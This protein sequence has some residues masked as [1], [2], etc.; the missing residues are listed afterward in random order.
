MIVDFIRRF[1]FS[2]S[3]YNYFKKEQLIHNKRLYEK[4]GLNKKY[5]SSISSKDFIGL[6]D[7]KNWLDKENSKTSLLQ[8]NFFKN[9]PDQFKEPLLNW[10]DNGFV[11][12]PKMF[13]AETQKINAEIEQ[14]LDKKIVKWK[15]GKKI[16]FAIQKSAYLSSIGL[17]PQ[18][19]GVMQMLLGRKI[20]L[21]QSINFFSGSQQRTHSDF[22]HMSTFPKGNLIA[23]WIALEDMCEENGPLH[24]YPGS[25]KLPCILNKDYQND[26]NSFM[27]GNKTYDKYEDEVER[28][29]NQTDLKKDKF[30]AK[31]GDALI[32]HSNLL[33]GG[34]EVLNPKLTR[35]SMVFHYY[36]HDVICYHE[37]TQR[38]TIME[39]LPK[40]N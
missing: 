23:V 25:H 2:F 16:M 33:H 6:P 10:S 15:N 30:I 29:L 12:L 36:A 35:K 9:L 27:V 38:P 39:K 14:L 11:V 17:N 28:I 40:F 21:F 34:E 32:W 24:Y 5:Y 31:K 37:I 7:E 3:F 13:E 20:E 18:L 1:K 26:G 8:N 22:V 4:Y 19:K